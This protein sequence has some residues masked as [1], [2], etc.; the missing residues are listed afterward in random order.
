MHKRGQLGIENIILFGALL[1][2]LTAILY[3]SMELISYNY[4]VSQLQDAV[5]MLIL[6]ANKIYDA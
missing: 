5:D 6:S 3:V 2:F 4:R 1:I